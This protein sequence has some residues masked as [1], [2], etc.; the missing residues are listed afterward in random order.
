MSVEDVEPVV[1][2]ERILRRSLS[3]CRGAKPRLMPRAVDVNEK[4]P[5]LAVL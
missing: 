4:F 1:E 5:S 2:R 3:D